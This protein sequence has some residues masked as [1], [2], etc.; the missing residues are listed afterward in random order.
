MN[1]YLTEAD[2]AEMTKLSL[3]GLRNG[4]Y[5]GKGIPYIKIG[6]S[7]R[8]KLEDV[9]SFMDSRRVVTENKC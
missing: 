5:L 4:R 6:R 2:V 7:V 1:Q 8:Y 3:S 9:I